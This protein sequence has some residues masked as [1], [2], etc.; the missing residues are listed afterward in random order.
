M[1]TNS[2]SFLGSYSGITMDTIEQLLSAE[3][4]KITS[5]KNEQAAVEKEKSA[6]KDVQT[7]ITNLATKMKNIK[8]DFYWGTIEV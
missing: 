7:R 6:W 3:S 1:S 5:Y 8:K 2:L 4:T